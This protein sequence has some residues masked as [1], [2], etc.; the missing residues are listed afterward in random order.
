MPTILIYQFSICS[1]AHPTTFYQELPAI[2]T[3]TIAV[4]AIRLL[5]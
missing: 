2:A 4:I 5:L 1:K 3:A